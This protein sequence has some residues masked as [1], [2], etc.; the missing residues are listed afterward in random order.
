MCDKLVR[1]G[2][3][4]SLCSRRGV[5]LQAASAA[6]SILATSIFTIV[7]IASKARFALS[8]S[9][10]VVRSSSRVGVICQEKPQRYGQLAAFVAAWKITGGSVDPVDMAIGKCRGVEFRCLACFAVVEPQACNEVGHIHFSLRLGR[11]RS[12]AA[13]LLGTRSM[14]YSGAKPGPSPDLRVCHRQPSP[15]R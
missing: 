9:E 13:A 6:A 3:G 11:F 15:K 10:L 2:Q 7:I 5:P 14:Y 1:S 4:V 8:R 12:C